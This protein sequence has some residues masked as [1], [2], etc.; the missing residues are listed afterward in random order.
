M[1]LGEL[2]PGDYVDYVPDDLSTSII[3]KDSGYDYSQLYKT[4]NTLKWQ[5]LGLNKDGN[6]MLISSTNIFKDNSE[7]YLTLLGGE[8]YLFGEKILNQI[9]SIYKNQYAVEARSITREDIDHL[10]NVDVN[11][12]NYTFKKKIGG[13]E[14]T[15]TIE[16]Q[17]YKYKEVDYAPENHVIEK[18][19][20][21]YNDIQGK[22]VDDEL[23]VN[24]V[25]YYKMQDSSAVS[26]AS[27]YDY[28]ETYD[29]SMGISKVIYELLFDKTFSKDNFANSDW[30]AN[31][32]INAHNNNY[33]T[34]GM[35]AV[36]NGNSSPR[37]CST[38]L[39]KWNMGIRLLWS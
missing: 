18:H 23:I 15:Y 19:L 20:F 12:D 4:D 38:I 8:G 17:V 11:Y 36:T 35:T 37:K 7:K 3:T 14:T 24:G 1:N 6:I 32:G 30:L 16:P 10:L 27:I 34:F 2:K 21:A 31:S 5:V 33:A 28:P 9:C 39:Y 25:L 22:Y 26:T 29:E 13:R